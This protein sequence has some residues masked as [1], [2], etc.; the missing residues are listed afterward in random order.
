MTTPWKDKEGT[1]DRIAPAERRRSPRA[2]VNLDQIIYMHFQSGNGG[3]V[4]DISSAG[5]GFQAA[6]PVE[7]TELLRFR[8]SPPTIEHIEISGQVVWLDKKRKRGGL[9]LNHLPVEVRKEIQLWRRQQVPP[10]TDAEQ[11]AGANINLAPQN[12]NLTLGRAASDTV[13]P[14]GREAVPSFSIPNHVR[15]VAARVEGSPSAA[16]GSSA[17]A[18]GPDLPP[19]SPASGA[20]N[21]LFS[22]EWKFSALSGPEEPRRSR[23]VSI[24]SLIVVLL[25]IA[26]GF[27]Y[28]GGRRRVGEFLIRLGESI[29]GEQWNVSMQTSTPAG[30]NTASTTASPAMTAKTVDSSGSAVQNSEVTGSQPQT[31]TTEQ[32]QSNLDQ[33]H[34]STGAKET[35]TGTSTGAKTSEQG[36]S[37]I[38]EQAQK[39]PE[40]TEH[41]GDNGESELAQAQK[42]LQGTSRADTARA[43]ELLWEAVGKGSSDAEVELAYLYLRGE[44]AVPKNCE[45]ARILLKA[46]QKNHNPEADELM[47]RLRAYGCR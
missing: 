2:Q 37:S 25:L 17:S 9:R 46:A 21:P 38:H 22:S 26:A 5:L 39:A 41:R 11:P 16:R 15:E 20:S 33:M 45:Q 23:Y 40:S 13:P 44:G 8:L 28:F 31:P 27:L 24:V 43:A 32:P 18:S 30:D 29:S 3:I 12:T 7:E 42:Y 10:A 34:T 6:H 14:A 47:G 35:D 36:P 1:L 19:N 4:L